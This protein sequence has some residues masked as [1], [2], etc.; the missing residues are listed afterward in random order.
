MKHH[1][2]FTLLVGASCLGIFTISGVSATI[3][4]DRAILL[5]EVREI[6]VV[7]SP[8]VVSI[9]GEQGFP[10]ISGKLGDDQRAPLVVAARWEKGRIVAFG[11]EGYLSA[12]DQ[13]DT[14]KL[15]RNA[16]AWTGGGDKTK[17]KVGVHG[18]PKLSEFL[19]AEH[20]QTE[21]LDGKDW[22]QKI[23]TV[24]VICTDVHK[25]EPDEV[26]ALSRF[27]RDG[28]GLVVSGLGWGWQQGNASKNLSVDFPG[29]RLLAPA[30]IVWGDGV[31]T[32][33]SNS[34]FVVAPESPLLN[35]KTAL[36]TILAHSA[37]KTKLQ[38]DELSQATAS[39]VTALRSIPS[40]D[41]LFLP[42]MTALQSN[43]D[44]LIFPGPERPLKNDKPLARLFVTQN[45]IALQRAEPNK[46]RLHP[47]AET[48]PG[49]VPNGVL[50]L[51]GRLIKVDTARPDWHSTGLYAPPGAL[52]RL[53]VPANATGKGLGVRI[54]CHT[55]KLWK[56]DSWARM[57][58]IS[59]LEKV[60]T[61]VT[62]AAN[63]FGG[64]IY[65]DVPKG[66]TLGEIEVK[67]SGGIAA[68]YYVLGKTD[69]KEW[70][71]EGRRAPAPW[72]ELECA[73]VILSVPSS[74][75]RELENPEELMQLWLKIVQAEDALAGIS[76][77]RLRP[78]RIVADAQISVGYMHSGYPIMTHLDVA[79]TATNVGKLKQNGW[80]F[81]HELGHNHQVSDWTFEGTGEVT[82]NVF[83]LFVCETVC[84]L[85][86]GSGHAAMDPAKVMERLNKHLDGHAVFARWQGDPFLALTMYDQLRA[87]FGWDT[88]RRVFAE[89]RSLPKAE[90]PTNDDQKRDQWM[91]RFSKAAGK[92]LGPFFQAWGVPTSDAARAAVQSLP[93]WMPVEWP[94]TPP[95]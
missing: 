94:K 51:N 35:A 65:V 31:L 7:G 90:R 89:Y 87:A 81:F 38:A 78:E 4:E 86:A 39:I 17:I 47:A 33:T 57:P 32:R 25:L 60:L 30:G 28:G 56:K 49:A 68:P 34:G 20:F 77:D 71:N 14:G 18:R 46:L 59:R 24:Q 19:K 29:N 10:L 75:I 63:S 67:I 91:V 26:T 42:Q 5:N 22:I 88:Y 85:P 44:A 53:E 74:A 55:D 43:P 79:T 69:L 27:T 9:F 61:P 54:G 45:V 64:L 12:T 70:V 6:G 48:F 84:G 15:L 95:Q 23:G 16:V 58:E 66:C 73:G 13:G 1:P 50:P 82:C 21:A 40:D 2:Q 72:A 11:H 37:N 92:N 76:A 8:G 36:T 80:G 93:Q 41:Q 62:E 83:A 52:I 3:D